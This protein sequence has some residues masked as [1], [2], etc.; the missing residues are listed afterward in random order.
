[1]AADAPKWEAEELSVEPVTNASLVCSD[2]D[3]K[4]DDDGNPA[5]VSKCVIFPTIKPLNVLNGGDCSEHS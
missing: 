3:F 1:M 2:C 5:N 4:Y